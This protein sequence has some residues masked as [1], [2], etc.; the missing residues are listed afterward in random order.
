MSSTTHRGKRLAIVLMA[1]GLALLLGLAICYRDTVRDHVEAWHFQWTRE[2]VTFS[3]NDKDGI[4]GPGLRF[5]KLSSS[6]NRRVIFESRELE[7]HFISR[8]NRESL[9]ADGMLDY[10]K[11][12]GY[13]V[14]E[15][16]FPRRAYV[17]IRDAESIPDPPFFETL[18]IPGA[19]VAE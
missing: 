6:S 8:V 5:R 10:L 12:D 16:R 2:T 19:A 18:V 4:W 3:P 14:I 17:V 7:R 15:Q 1:S 13:C 9:T 11:D